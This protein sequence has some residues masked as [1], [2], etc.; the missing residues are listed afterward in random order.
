MVMALA[1]RAAEELVFGRVTNGAA[2]DLE[3]ATADRPLDGVRVGDGRHG[4]LADGP[5]RRLRALGGDEAPARLRSRPSS[6]I[7]PTPSRCGC[8]ACTAPR[9]TASPPRCSSARRCRVTSWSSCSR[10]S[11]RRRAPRTRSAVVRGPRRV[12]SRVRARLAARD[13][14]AR[15][16]PIRGAR[17]RRVS[18]DQVAARGGALP[19]RRAARPRRGAREAQPAR[20]GAGA[21]GGRRLAVCGGDAPR[22]GGGGRRR[23]PALGERPAPDWRGRLRLRPG[24]PGPRLRDRG[25][26]RRRR[27]GVRRRSACT[28]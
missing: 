8:S 3:R 16:A 9:S 6:P 15:A 24:P 14:A 28:A 27:L 11:S 4:H 21:R 26:A 25:C 19:L 23:R 12:T 1:G 17:L 13:R 10:A 5:R 18:R 7:R 2:N 22:V 20:L